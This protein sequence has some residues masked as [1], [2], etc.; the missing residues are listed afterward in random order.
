MPE[1]GIKKTKKLL[2]TELSKLVAGCH[3]SLGV[4]KHILEVI[5]FVSMVCFPANLVRTHDNCISCDIL[6]DHTS[7]LSFFSPHNSV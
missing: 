5:S 2:H 1:C 3:L 6:L 4:A 7:I